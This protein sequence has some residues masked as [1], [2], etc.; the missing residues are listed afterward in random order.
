MFTAKLKMDGVLRAVSS[1]CEQKLQAV[2][3][4]LDRFTKTNLPLEYTDP[5][6]IELYYHNDR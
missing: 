3:D 6:V 1:S 4:V 2:T 5:L